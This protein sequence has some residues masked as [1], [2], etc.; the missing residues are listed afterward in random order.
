M[1][2][3]SIT[4]SKIRS[5]N[6]FVL[7]QYVGSILI[8]NKILLEE[9]DLDRKKKLGKVVEKKIE[10]FDK[11]FP[12]QA[13][14]LN[15]IRKKINFCGKHTLRTD[16]IILLAE[17]A[18]APPF[19]PYEVKYKESHFNTAYKETALA[20]K[21]PRKEVESIINIK[22]AATSSHNSNSLFKGL[23]MGFG[24]AAL[25]G[26]GG[27]FLAPA[28]VGLSGAAAAFFGLAL[29]GGEEE[30]IGKGMWVAG[31]MW[32]VNDFK[33]KV[34][35]TPASLLISIPGPS[36]INELIKIQIIFNKK[37]AKT[38]KIILASLEAH[39]SAFEQ[40]I[41]EDRQYNDDGSKLIDSHEKKFAA[42]TKTIKWMNE[43]I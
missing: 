24:G 25:V 28:L 34:G 27:W 41:E 4:A 3:K 35:M 7:Y 23:L 8:A 31:G 36:L 29:L 10:L 14:K 18:C 17:L 6:N 33:T 32:L 39:L 13:K 12:V 30:S 37:N 20:F 43:S 2:I 26:M 11:L 16:K 19:A 15:T 40:K 1:A 38:R 21:T 5:N 9:T 42:L 22:K